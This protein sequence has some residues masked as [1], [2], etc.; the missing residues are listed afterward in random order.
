MVTAHKLPTAMVEDIAE[1]LVVAVEDG[2]VYDAL[3]YF[4]GTFSNYEDKKISMATAIRVAASAIGG[5]ATLSMRADGFSA[6]S[7]AVYSGD[8]DI[9][10]I[11][12]DEGTAWVLDE[13]EHL[14]AV[15]VMLCKD[16]AN[17]EL[18][19]PCPV[20]Y[21]PFDPVGFE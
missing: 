17:L 15:D 11:V 16:H 8:V 12:D 13:C 1:R 21:H 6:F 9:P 2:L 4:F 10:E 3:I 5:N 19:V 20:N 18:E 7:R 14:M